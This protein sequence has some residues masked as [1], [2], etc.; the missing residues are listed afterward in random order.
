VRVEKL[1]ISF[2]ISF[3]M[4]TPTFFPLSQAMTTT[5]AKAATTSSEQEHTMTVTTLERDGVV[6]TDNESKTTEQQLS[7]L[8][9]SSSEKIILTSGDSLSALWSTVIETCA[10]VGESINSNSTK[11]LSQSLMTFQYD[12]YEQ[13]VHV[14]D[15]VEDRQ[16]QEDDGG[17]FVEE[18]KDHPNAESSVR[19]ETPDDTMCKRLHPVQEGHTVIDVQDGGTETEKF[20]TTATT[21]KNLGD[22]TKSGS[23]DHEKSMDSKFDNIGTC[24][25]VE[26]SLGQQQKQQ[27][28]KTTT[29]QQ[30]YDFVDVVASTKQ[31]KYVFVEVF[32]TTPSVTYAYFDDNIHHQ[33]N[34]HKKKHNKENC[35]CSTG[36][37][38]M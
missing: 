1:T 25:S 17:E 5:I 26:V 27:A 12:Q 14:H 11:V 38:L 28:Q 35:E 4:Q 24:G 13:H 37:T 18:T 20:T 19:T 7:D 16:D 23:I 9:L 22:D 30:K 3:P 29:K 36:C 15:G 21:I 8:L 10:S 33:S 32:A 31:K 2:C 6:A 34:S